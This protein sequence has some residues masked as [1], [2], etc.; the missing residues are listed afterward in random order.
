MKEKIFAFAG[1]SGVGKT[2]LLTYIEANFNIKVEE[3][4]ARPFLPRNGKDYVDSLNK[5]SQVLITMNRFTSFLEAMLNNEP[6][7]FTR[8]TIDSLAYEMVLKKAPFLL[9][10][11][12]RQ[13]EVTKEMATYLYIPIEFEMEE[14]ADRVRGTNIEIQKQTDGAIQQIL[15]G[16]NIKY[17]VVKGSKEE[18][19]AILD[20]I[21]KDY[22]Y[23]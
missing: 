13:V 15:K 16:N 19:F 6:T 9:D 22:K 2:T 14:S 3:L 11:F 17:R 21:F 4:S 23:E 18:R 8:S 5:E 20:E 12:N 10:L 7:V 1:A